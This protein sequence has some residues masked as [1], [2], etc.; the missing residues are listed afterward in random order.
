M[1]HRK[2]AAS[3][4]TPRSHPQPDAKHA[5]P[6]LELRRTPW[7]PSAQEKWEQDSLKWNGHVLQG[8][9]CH[10][11]HDWD[12]LPIDETCPE[13]AVCSCEFRDWDMVKAEMHREALQ[14]EMD[15]VIPY[16]IR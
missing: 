6:G 3:V 7:S 16:S 10:W 8:E 15:R 13:F 12:D 2:R 14:S 9:F 1:S 4:Q 5:L 11:C